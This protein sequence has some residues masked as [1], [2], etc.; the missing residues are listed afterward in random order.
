MTTFAKYKVNRA[1]R[2]SFLK[3]ETKTGEAFGGE[4]ESTKER[5]DVNE[6]TRKRK[7]FRKR[8][9]IKMEISVFWNNDDEQTTYAQ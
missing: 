1:K 6:T 3:R 8:W 7:Q 2:N 4:I 5:I 9:T